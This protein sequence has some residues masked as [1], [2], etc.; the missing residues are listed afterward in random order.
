MSR[1]IKFLIL[2][3]GKGTRM[4]S[5]LPKVL[6]PLGGKPMIRHLLET[7]SKVYDDKPI[8]IVGYK[9][10]L[11]KAEL[12]DSC[13]YAL[14]KEQLGTGHAVF[15]A[16]DYCEDADEIV[17]LSG[18]QP[19]VKAETIKKTIEKH[20]T[21]KAKITFTTTEI[22]DF[23]D[24]RKYF[25]PL[26]RI[27][28]KNGEIVGIR[29]YK[30]ANEEEK[31]IREINTACCYIFDAKWLWENLPKIKNNN[32]KNEFYITDLFYIASDEKENIETVKMSPEESM[33]ANSKEDLE[34]LQKFTA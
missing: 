17:V 32:A 8:V 20:E 3:A 24:W 19:F 28:R 31:E 34:I 15:S 11:V 26:G 21:E 29:E 23:L 5:D 9:A 4:N 14:Q 22:P 16:K 12:G 7:I 1:K 27:L 2:A 10:E 13:I 6:A 33:G 18:D 30:D 25:I